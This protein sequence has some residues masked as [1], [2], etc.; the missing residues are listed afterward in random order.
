MA[1]LPFEH[2]VVLTWAV[3]GHCAEPQHWAPGGQ[4]LSSSEVASEPPSPFL[5]PPPVSGTPP[6]GISPSASVAQATSGGGAITAIAKTRRYGE[7]AD[8]SSTARA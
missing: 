4:P 7:M 3:C 6:S 1:H 5:S 8:R 2:V